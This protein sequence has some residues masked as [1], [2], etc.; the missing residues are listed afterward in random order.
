[1]QPFD[2]THCLEMHSGLTGWILVEGNPENFVPGPAVI[3]IQN[4]DPA[5]IQRAVFTVEPDN[6]VDMSLNENQRI[7]G[8]ELAYMQILYKRDPNEQTREATA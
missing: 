7:V 6:T 2:F 3:Y 8:V 5:F 4:S 1:M